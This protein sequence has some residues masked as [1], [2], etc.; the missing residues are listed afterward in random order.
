MK[1]VFIAVL[2][3]VVII[4]ITPISVL[5][6]EDYRYSNYNQ[7]F[8]F[9]EESGG[10]NFDMAKRRY[11]GFLASHPN[12]KKVD[13]Q[14]YRNFTLKPWRFWEWREMLLNYDRYELPYKPIGAQ[15]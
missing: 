11:Q 8:T 2:V 5:W 6:I 1:K 13:S 4:N 14:L 12:E 9:R 7:S 10:Y 15:R 3:I